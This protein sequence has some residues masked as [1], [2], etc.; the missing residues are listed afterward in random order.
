MK[1][2]DYTIIVESY[3][4]DEGGDWDRFRKSLGSAASLAREDDAEVLALDVCGLPELRRILEQE[5]SEVKVIDATDMG[6]DT[7]KMKAVQAASGKYVLF[8]DGDCLPLPGW[9]D[10]L[11]AA[12]RGNQSVAVGGY[13]RYDGGFLA[14][15]CSV[16]DFGFMYPCVFRDMGCYAFNNCG[17]DREVLLA[18]PAGGRNLRCA[19]YFHAQQF[20]R[21]G[22]PMKLIPEGR[23]LHEMQPLIRE[24]TRQGFDTIAACWED[25]E[26]PEAR[27]LKLGVLSIPLYYA[28]NLHL[29]W[30]RAL[31]AR[32]PLGQSWLQLVLALSLFPIF[33]LLDIVGMFH[34]FLGGRKEGGWGGNLL[35]RRSAGHE[36]HG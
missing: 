17:F 26:I 6:Y 34:A 35:K 9:K 30:R 32:K 21:R 10:H 28:R 23:V 29:D 33:R 18:V 7:G 27:F 12:L 31:Q 8:L 3:T 22:T 16:L 20:L 15:V 2:P 19:C 13:T 1:T 24:R 11:L 36:G 25:P 4:L 5:F 14:G